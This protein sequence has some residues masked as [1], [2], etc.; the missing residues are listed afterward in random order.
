MDESD[1]TPHPP[2]VESTGGRTIFFAILALIGAAVGGYLLIGA[3]K[4]DAARD[5]IAAPS[6][7]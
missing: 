4:S 1:D 5:R 3:I 7:R 2:E 6:G